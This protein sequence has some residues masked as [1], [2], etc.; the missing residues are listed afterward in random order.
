MRHDAVPLGKGSGGSLV[1]WSPARQDHLRIKAGT[2]R[3]YEG[4]IRL[5]L[6]PHLG[7]LRIDRLRP[8]HIDAM[9]DAIAERNTTI[10]TLRASRDPAKRAQVKNQRIVG[11]RTLHVIHA[12]LRKPSTTRCAA[13]A[14][15]TPTPPS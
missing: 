15:S 8:G 4:H 7:H 2:L 13:T 6:I 9:Y 14:T 12:T 11:N 10:A 1:G 5:Y 3:S